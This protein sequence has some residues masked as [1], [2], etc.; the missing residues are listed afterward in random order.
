MTVAAPCCPCKIIAVFNTLFNYCTICISL[1]CS[2]FC[3]CND[4]PIRS[5]LRFLHTMSISSYCFFS[6]ERLKILAEQKALAAARIR[7]CPT[8]GG[9]MTET[10]AAAAAAGAALTPVSGSDAPSA[11]AA[12]AA[13]PSCISSS[14]ASNSLASL[15][16]G[17][18]SSGRSRISNTSTASDGP[19]SHFSAVGTIAARS[20]TASGDD[21]GSSS[22]K[23]ASAS[24]SELPKVC[25]CPQK[26]AKRYRKDRER[27]HGMI[28]FQDLNKE[29]SRRWKLVQPEEKARYQEM[30]KRDTVRYKREME[31]Y[32]A[33]KAAAM[34]MLK[35]TTA[36]VSAGNDIDSSMSSATPAKPK[37]RPGAAAAVEMRGATA[38]VAE[39]VSG[40]PNPYNY[41]THRSTSS[42]LPPSLI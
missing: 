19:D 26:P 6:E 40:L 21:S 7:V 28:S 23:S 39:A 34:D 11:A 38:A 18:V 15:S 16:D 24:A 31:E 22:N 5:S 25:A 12:T 17:N 2:H 29:I 27:P 20:S 36:A 10:A 35:S 41:P 13:A 30:T 32:K 42:N 1:I 9:D 8:Y 33:E 37:G 4:M 3:L 14:S